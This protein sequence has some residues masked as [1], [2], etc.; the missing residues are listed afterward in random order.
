MKITLTIFFLIIAVI[1][2]L[3]LR[4]VGFYVSL[5]NVSLAYLCVHLLIVKTE[6][7]L[8]LALGVG[9]IL[10]WFSGLPD[11]VMVISLPAGIKAAQYVG[12][13]YFSERFHVYILPVHVLTAT[14]VTMITAL[15]V[16]GVM[17][18][19]GWV[20]APDWQY[21]FTWLL[22]IT[23]GLNLL[24]LI[25]AYGLQAIELFIQKRYIPKT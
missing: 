7:V 23:I 15:L 3:A 6:E 20:Q 8:W 25:P 19:I 22:P 13:M 16:L 1:F 10:D 4:E 17:A 12:E 2:Q 18:L 9:I 24:S 5:A 21:Y 11:G 14:I